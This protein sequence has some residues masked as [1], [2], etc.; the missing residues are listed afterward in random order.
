MAARL[1]SREEVVGG[2]PEADLTPLIEANLSK[3]L[4]ALN[5]FRYA[6]GRPMM[7]SSGLR[8]RQS[9][10][11]LSNS[12]KN[13]AHLSGEACD[14]HD[15]DRAITN[16]VMARPAILEECGLYMEEPAATPTWIHLGVRRPGSGNRIF[17]PF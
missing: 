12:G 5:K 1:I 16:F 11:Q 15:I 10:D 14:F 4:D 6:Y 9:N 8:T 2:Y 7:V 3:L 13:S 17:R